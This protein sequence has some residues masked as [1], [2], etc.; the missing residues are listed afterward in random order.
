M[1]WH[2]APYASSMSRSIPVPQQVAVV[3]FDDMPFA[4]RSQPPLTTVRQPIIQT[5]AMAAESLIARIEDP[6]QA[7]CP[8]NLAAHRAGHSPVVWE[9]K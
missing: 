2:W 3:G 9:Q 7:G 5:G 4:A 6:D 1:P 8:A